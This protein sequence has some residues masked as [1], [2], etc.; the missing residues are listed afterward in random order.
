MSDKDRRKLLEPQP[1]HRGWGILGS[2]CV[3][4]TLLFVTLTGLV[5]WLGPFSVTSQ[6]AILFHTL[7]GLSLLIPFTLWQLRHWRA[8]R[9]APRSASKVSAYVGFWILAANFISGLVITYQAMFGLTSSHFWTGVHR[10]T[11]ILVFPLLV[12]HVFPRR[13]LAGELEHEALV[14]TRRH[15]GFARRSMWMWSLGSAALLFAALIGASAFYRSASIADYTPPAS[16][17]AAP[18]ANPFA[19]SNARTESRRP[20]PAGSIS[21]SRA[22]GAPGCHTAVYEEW[23]AS[24]HRWSEED[25]F[26][27]AVRTA[28]TEVQ[29]IYATEKCGGC[30]APVSMLS[31][32]KDPTLGSATSGYREGDSCAVCHA[33]RQVDERGIGSYVLGIPKGYLYDHNQGCCAAFINHFVIRVYPG[34]HDQD[35]NLK[36]ARDA[37]S[38][39][40]CHKEYDKVGKYPGLLEVETQY[41]D[42][43]SHKWNTDRD[44]TRRLRCQQCHMYLERAG[45]RSLADPYDLAVGLGLEYHNHRFAAANQHMPLALGSPGAEQ[46]TRDVNQWLTGKTEISEIQKVWPHGSIIPIKIEALTSVRAGAALGVRVVLTN[47]KAGHSFPTGPLNIVRVWIELEVYDKAGKKVFHSGELDRENHIEAGSY[48]LRPIA[49]TESGHSILTPDIWHPQGPQFRPAINPGE[50]ESFEYRFPVPKTVSGPLLVRARLRYRKANQFF[51]NE[52]Y[53]PDHREAPVTDL[54]SASEQ[55]AVV[56]ALP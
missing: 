1:V 2:V 52:V 5:V 7:A 42:W 30:H 55:T 35:Y 31:G 40:P 41:D 48:I 18:G 28:T 21:D 33:V 56:G 39:A 26:F 25:Q 17:R 9:I 37:G 36:I 49:L 16:F 15:Y 22:C 27:Q 32:Y 19:P 50:S 38:C 46:Q 4:G 23:R 53:D 3:G 24:A 34:Q 6:M 10:W 13:A 20:V 43:K 51:M 47:N 54:S 29:G 11:G 14:T 8:N 45:A 44:R 12:F